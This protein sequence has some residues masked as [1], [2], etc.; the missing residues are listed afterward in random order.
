M[1]YI[2]GTPSKYH[3][4]SSG[5]SLLQEWLPPIRFNVYE[6]VFRVEVT[7]TLSRDLSVDCEQP[8]IVSEAKRTLHSL[9]RRIRDV[10]VQKVG[11]YLKSKLEWDC[12]KSTH[13]DGILG[14][15]GLSFASS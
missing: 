11:I 1:F 14:F 10:V 6:F 2:A 5:T 12:N 7:E 9:G 3:R 15:G 13:D 4:E 8:D